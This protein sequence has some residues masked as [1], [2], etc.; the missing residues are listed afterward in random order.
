MS[1][2][3]VCQHYK[4]CLAEETQARREL[5]L[6]LL[7][8]TDLRAYSV[9]MALRCGTKNAQSTAAAREL[10]E[11]RYGSSSPRQVAFS[12]IKGVS[13][14]TNCVGAP[15]WLTDLGDPA[16]ARLPLAKLK[17]SPCRP[18]TNHGAA[19]TNAVRL[20][21]TTLS[22]CPLTPCRCTACVACS[23][24]N[25][26]GPACSAFSAFC[27]CYVF[28]MLRLFVASRGAFRCCT[29]FVW[30]V[31]EKLSRTVRMAGLI[32]YTLTEDRGV[33]LPDTGA[34]TLVRTKDAKR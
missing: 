33:D 4:V 20:V 27:A 21:R 12:L 5:G 29:R 11:E 28:P 8:V 6:A 13:V 19:W 2:G 34:W 17:G 10:F 9:Q 31:Q 16:A 15:D 24:S 32:A 26:S 22:T 3:R 7:L 18:D 30:L 25:A 23:L 1:L 14:C